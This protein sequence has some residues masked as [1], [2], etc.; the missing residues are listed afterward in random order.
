MTDPYTHDGRRVMLGDL[1]ISV[2]PTPEQAR[3]AADA[4]NRRRPE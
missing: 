1:V 3:A 2:L 4:M